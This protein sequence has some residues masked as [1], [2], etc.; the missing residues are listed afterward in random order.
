MEHTGGLGQ[1]AEVWVDGHLLPV[2]DSISRPQDRCPPG[3]LEGA[4][5][6]YMTAEGFT[7][8]EAARGNPAKRKRL[9]HE[10][11]WRYTGYGQVAQVMPVIVDFGLV[12]MEDANWTTD[13]G[14]VGRFVRIP[15][16][17]LEIVPANAPDFPAEAK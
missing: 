8:A 7:W 15:I 5:L 12:R 2:C 17:R 6:S 10:R 13:E 14:L 4:K 9:E 1:E 3:V 11:S 16:D